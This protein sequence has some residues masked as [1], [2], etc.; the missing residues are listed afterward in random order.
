MMAAS[1]Q[2]WWDDHTMH[3]GAFNTSGLAGEGSTY[4]N[5]IRWR[6]VDELLRRFY[7]DVGLEPGFGLMGGELYQVALISPTC[8]RAPRSGR[9]CGIGLHPRTNGHHLP[10]RRAPLG[11]GGP[12][13]GR[14][15]MVR[16]CVDAHGEYLLPVFGPAAT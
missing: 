6:L 15:I 10:A 4:T 8:R 12:C 11:L 1:D 9:L 5:W 16:G 2:S 14:G 3:L 7:T 13:G